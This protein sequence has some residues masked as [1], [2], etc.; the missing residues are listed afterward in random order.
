M[1]EDGVKKTNLRQSLNKVLQEKEIKCK[2]I[3]CREPGAREINWDGIKL[4][5]YDYDSSGGREVFLSFE[6]VENDIMLGFIRLR[7][8]GKAFRPEITDKTVGIREIKVYGAAA[9]LGEVGKV[10]HRGLGKRLLIEAERIAKE[11]FNADK[12]LV[13]S[14]IGT[15]EYFRKLG[16]SEDGVYMGKL[17]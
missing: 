5:R 10:Q 6:D 15:K 16:Y 8:P 3:R 2:C 11:E 14:S 13:M 12:I 7:K 17:L 1:I 9:K 4:L